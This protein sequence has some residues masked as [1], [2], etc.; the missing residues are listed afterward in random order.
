MKAL[1]RRINELEARQCRGQAGNHFIPIL[2]YPWDVDPAAS[3]TWLA[4][5]I[6]CDC[7]SDCPGKRVGVLVPAKCTPGEWTAKAQAYSQ[8]RVSG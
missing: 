4:Q 6:A 1:E 7:R 8:K 3:D 2:Q 5:Q